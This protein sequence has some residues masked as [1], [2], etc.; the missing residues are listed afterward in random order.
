MAG[1]WVD[2]VLAGTITAAGVV[3]GALVF[4]DRDFGSTAGPIAG[5]LATGLATTALVAAYVIVRR[6]TV[7]Q[8]HV[9]V[10]LVGTFLVPVGVAAGG[11]FHDGRAVAVCWGMAAFVAHL[12]IEYARGRHG[13]PRLGAA[14]VVV[15]AV[16]S[17]WLVGRVGQVTWQTEDLRAVGVPL[18]VV[19][20]PGFTPYL[21]GAGTASVEVVLAERPHPDESSGRRITVTIYRGPASPPCGSSAPTMIDDA[22]G[23]VGP[24]TVRFCVAEPA[25]VVVARAEPVYRQGN[26]A[27]EFWSI[28][29]LL[30]SMTLRPVTAEDL[31][32]LGDVTPWE[33]D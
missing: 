33:T 2:G 4:A 17:A 24:R 22:V 29:P 13:K 5:C 32:R 9:L 7:S 12:A 20:V 25:H 19:D 1:R 26:S 16:A 21:A 23:E 31:A 27:A 18:V 15:L 28:E 6:R 30:P 10:P 8:W 11:P 14:L 3:A